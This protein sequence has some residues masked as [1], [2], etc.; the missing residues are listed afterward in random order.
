VQR[1]ALILVTAITLHA[2]AGDVRAYGAK[3]DG[4]ADDYAAVAAAIQTASASGGTVYFPRGSYFLGT[5]LQA[6]YSNLHLVCEAGAVLRF[7]VSGTAVAFANDAPRAANNIGIENCTIDGGGTASDGI[8]LQRSHHVFFRNV[9][10]RNVTRACL[11]TKFSVIGEYTNF[12][13]TINEEGA[14]TMPVNGL[15]LGEDGPGEQTTAS[16]FVNAIVEGVAADGIVLDSAA[17]LVFTAGTSENHHGGWGM[18]ISPKSANITVAGMDFEDNLL[19][20]V[21]T[22]GSENLFLNILATGLFQV[23]SGARGNTIANSRVHRVV[24]DPGSYNNVMRETDYAIEDGKPEPADAGSNNSIY[25]NYNAATHRYASGYVRFPV[26][27]ASALLASSGRDSAF[28]NVRV[29][30]SWTAVAA[31]PAATRW[32]AVLIGAWSS[33]A[34][35]TPAMLTEATPAS[36]SAAILGETVTFRVN[37]EAGVLEARAPRGIALRFTG[38]AFVTA[39]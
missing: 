22:S 14:A 36:P 38:A 12:R 20:A 1:I 11:R 8:L 2:Q 9:R 39:E 26:D 31:A 23:R 34:G 15:V 5:G 24:F 21:E 19:G 37:E 30:D 28:H 18:T 16:T 27:S 3:G 17:N 35:D 7:A 10:F 32:R 13:C 6:G 33:G 29:T 25:A 4:V